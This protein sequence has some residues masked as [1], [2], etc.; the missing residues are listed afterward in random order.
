MGFGRRLGG[1]RRF[2][3]WGW[4]GGH[5]S[6]SQPNEPDTER[7]A[8]KDQAGALKAEMEAIEKRLEALDKTSGE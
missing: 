1:R 2:G 5:F 6:P 3:G 8:L 4:L 7:Q